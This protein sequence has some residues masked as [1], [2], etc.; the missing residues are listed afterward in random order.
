MLR[1]CAVVVGVLV[2]APAI[3]QP[4]AD[5]PASPDPAPEPIRLEYAVPAGCPDQ[6]AFVSAIQAREAVVVA[7]DG[8]RTFA[9]TITDVPDGGPVN[10]TLAIT[11]AD[12]T[13]T[14][15]A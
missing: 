15:R 13:T 8:A 1:V 4:A 7:A 11:A 14:T 5:A 6:A 2:A 12:G 3:A 9:V 10:G